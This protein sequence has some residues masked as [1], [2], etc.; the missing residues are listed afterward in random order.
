[1]EEHQVHLDQKDQRELQEVEGQQDQ[2]DLQEIKVPKVEVEPQEDLDLEDHK[3]HQVDKVQKGHQVDKVQQDQQELRVH[4]VQQDLQG[5]HVTVIVY[6]QDIVGEMFVHL[7]II[8]YCI[9]KILSMTLVT[10]N[11]NLP[12]IVRLVFVIGMGY[13]L[14]YKV[15]LPQLYLLCSI[16]VDHVTPRSSVFTPMLD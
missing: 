11:I 1:V 4:K 15:L 2:R 7:H 13:F 12:L 8:H 14:I 3:G 9:N 16:L 6:L 5:L 10:T